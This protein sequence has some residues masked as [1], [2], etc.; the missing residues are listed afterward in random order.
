MV[1]DLDTE[2]AVTFRGLFEVSTAVLKRQHPLRRPV[3][4]QTVSYAPK[5]PKLESGG[6]AHKTALVT[7][8]QGIWFSC[9]EN[10]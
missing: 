3:K 6:G 1:E 4:A 5:S 9:L 7:S 10:H 2:G 8:S